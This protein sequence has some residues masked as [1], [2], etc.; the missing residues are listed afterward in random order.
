MEEQNPFWENKTL[1]QMT[2]EEWESLCDGCAK[3]CLHKI[4]AQDDGKVY[5]TNIACRLLDCESCRC[6][7]YKNRMKIIHDCVHLTPSLINELK[8]LPK[9]C[10]YRRLS[11]GRGLAWWHPLVSGDPDTVRQAK[12]S[13]CDRVIPESL[14]DITELEEY[15]V[16]WFD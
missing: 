12:I 10:A 14:I 11:E 3:C 16:D 4:Q 15:I 5:F 6:Q 8:W 9:T 2:H 7:N 13:I 1:D